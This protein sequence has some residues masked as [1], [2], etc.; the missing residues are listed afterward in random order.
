VEDTHSTVHLEEITQI[1][2]TVQNLEEAKLFYRDSLGMR[3]LFDAGAMAFFQCGQIRLMI[4]TSDKPSPS[5]GTIVYFRVPDLPS[6][7][8]ALRARNVTFVQEP[9]LV[10]RMKSHDLWLAFLKDPS[11]NPIGLMSEVARE[12]TP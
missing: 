12:I 7:F 5:S 8:S 10:A 1:A 6:A 3:F 11:G 4:G 2:L 9:H